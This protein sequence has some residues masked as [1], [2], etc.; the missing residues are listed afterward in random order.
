MRT[1]LIVLLGLV[2][3][4]AYAVPPYN[5]N[6]MYAGA[7]DGV[8][9]AV[10]GHLMSNATLDNVPDGATRKLVPGIQGPTGVAGP[11]GPT[12][13]QGAIGAT[14]QTGPTGSQ[15][16][17]GSTGAQGLIGPTGASGSQGVVGPTGLQGI[18]GPTG[19]QGTAGSTGPTGSSGAQ[20]NTGPIGPTGSIGLTGATGPTGVQGIQGVIGP[21]GLQG[22]TGPTGS[23]GSNGPTGPTGLTGSAGPTGTTGSTGT[24]GS[25]GPTGAA[26]STGQSKGGYLSVF[27]GSLVSISAGT[28][29]AIGKVA[30]TQLVQN[31]EAIATILS[32]C[33]SNPVVALQ[34]CT[35]SACSSPTSIGSVTLT[36][37]GVLAET[38]VASYSL[39]VGHYWRYTLTAG[40]CTTLS[41]TASAAVF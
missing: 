6:V 18:S 21:T 13:S 30:V 9:W 32:L 22:I 8:I 12:G 41:F 2:P 37:A 40:I 31:I 4:L 33:T 34:D 20:G 14:G 35:T 39:A 3:F 29:I 5:P 38:S 23:T 1:K 16:I 25:T 36:G 27:S 11:S 26:G 15:G 7:L 17:Q 24:I 28:T 19:A 10:A